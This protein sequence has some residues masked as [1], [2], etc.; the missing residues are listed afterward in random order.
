MC[1]EDSSLAVRAGGGR[2]PRGHFAEC[3]FISFLPATQDELKSS[4]SLS[5]EVLV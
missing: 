5:L 1:T 3:V 4:C 2:T